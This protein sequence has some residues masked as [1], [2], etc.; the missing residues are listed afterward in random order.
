MGK[1]LVVVGSLS[2]TAEDR[3]ISIAEA[4]VDVDAAIIVDVSGSMAA[5]DSQDGLS[6]WQV[7]GNELTGLQATM[8]GKLAVIAF[9]SQAE[10]MPAGI[11]PVMGRLG[12]GTDLAGALRFSKILDVPGVRF[13]VISDG[14]PG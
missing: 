4:L 13:V 6:R 5:C 14:V 8:P 9:A 10:F 11:L 3:S 1:Q 2:T 12:A 7:A